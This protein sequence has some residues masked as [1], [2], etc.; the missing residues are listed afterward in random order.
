MNNVINL[1]DFVFD[2]LNL[3]LCFEVSRLTIGSTTDVVSH[4]TNRNTV[5]LVKRQDISNPF[6]TPEQTNPPKGHSTRLR[7]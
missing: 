2:L 3:D 6:D 4:Y 5:S 7:F 1:I